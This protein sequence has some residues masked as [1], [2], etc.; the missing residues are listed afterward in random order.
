MNRTMN[1]SRIALCGLTLVLC[2]GCGSS[3]EIDQPQI[4]YSYSLEKQYPETIH[5]KERDLPYPRLQTDLYLNPSPLIVPQA[6]KTEARM[7]FELSQDFAFEKGEVI[8]S[9]A[10]AW[11]LFNPHR[12]LSE[13]RWYWRFRSVADDGT[14]K[15]WSDVVPFEV[16]PSATEFVTPPFATMRQNLP[17]GHPRLYPYLDDG[18]EAARRSVQSHPE[19][20]SLV[21]RANNSL[22]KDHSAKPYAEISDMK[23]ESTFLYAAYRLTLDERYAAQL[24]EN[25]R[26]LLNAPVDDAT[27]FASNFGATDIAICIIEPYD[28][29]WD[30]LTEAERT[31]ADALMMR[32]AERYFS[33]H[34][35]KQEN[36]LFDNHFWQ[37]NMRV[38]FQC[39]YMLYDRPDYADRALE[40][41]EYYYELWTAR[42]PDSGFNHSGIWRNGA[43][44]FDANIL[45]LHYMPMLYGHLTDCDFLQHPWYRNAG[46]ALAYTWPP[47]SMSAGFGDGADDAAAP[48]RIRV[49]FADFLARELN[50]SYAGWYAGQCPS[51]L[52]DDYQLRLYRIVRGAAAYS[53]QLPAEAPRLLWYQD[54]GEVV[55]HSDMTSPAGNLTLSFRSSPFGSGSHT[56]SD[57][58]SFNIL[59]GGQPVYRRTGYYLNF[60]DAHNITSYRHSRAHNTVLVDGIGQPFSTSAYGMVTRALSG[61][62]I[63]YC[64]G[65]ASQAY[66]GGNDAMWVENLKKAGIAETPENGFGPTP[67]SCYRRHVA[68]LHPN[69]VVIYD[70]LA[71][72]EPVSWQWLL[73]SPVRFT[74]DAAASR[75]TTRPGSGLSA[76][77]QL[78]SGE[79]PALSQTD[80]FVTPPDMN[81]AS[82]G[83][84]CPNQWHLTAG[85]GPSKGCRV[86]ALMQI[87]PSAAERES[88]V[89]TPEGIR[90]GK[91]LICAELDAGRTP[92]LVIVDTESGARLDYG[93]GDPALNG[94]TYRRERGLS[95]ILYDYSDGR[96]RIEEQ[97]D[98]EPTTTRSM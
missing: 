3:D 64:L 60:S 43:Y 97:S 54:A 4:D 27:L 31:T 76:S 40:M 17:A 56:Q 91:W 10:N 9:E 36:T 75:A 25:L 88:I 96:Y 62:H 59:Y 87:T 13:G 52:T 86:L 79:A 18:L 32:I 2:G 70:E 89:E 22:G 23:R 63:L 46:Q 81:L 7:Q 1:L 73:H 5:V 14:A 30:R 57:Q 45:T 24:L 15:P 84:E 37:H 16:K 49:A 8:R 20:K 19:Y 85:F 93:C 48:T 26:A 28:L 12:R 98:W 90:F 92:S 69:K 38:L 35:G 61:A 33:R 34:C 95:T 47:Q 72:E 78:F 55:M 41:M 50:D 77:T 29:L 80:Q 39:A 68:L 83:Q 21:G 44:Y 53:G 94:T 65:D 42:A 66:R 74:I 11:C 67:L 71:A 51:T 58:N 6:L 82:P